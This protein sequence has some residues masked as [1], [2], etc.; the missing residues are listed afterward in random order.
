MTAVT[1]VI[2]SEAFRHADA[3]LRR[4]VSEAGHI[5][6]D[7]SDSWW[8]EGFPHGLGKSATVFHGSLGNADRIA[9]ELGW[10]PGTYCDA[11]KFCCSAWYEGARP[12]LLHTDWRIL[13]A[14]DLVATAPS[15]AAE[16]GGSD[17]VFVRPDSP[18]KPFSGRVVDASSVTLAALDHG[19][20][21]DDA[22]LPIVVAPVRDVGRE[23]RFLVVNKTAV[24]GSGYDPATRSADASSLDSRALDFAQ[25][26]AARLPPPADV[27]ILD[28]CESEGELRLLELN[29][30]G[31]ADLYACDA[32]VVVERVSQAANQAWLR[33][34]ANQGPR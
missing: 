16:I 25:T 15:I 3:G 2:E 1:W 23:W 28:L 27:Y 5:A 9:R 29:P 20:Y 19:F 21:F 13:P 4:A 8:S 7:W 34:Q 30:F 22:S 18:L 6:I 32:G 26:I 12:W 33:Q 14:D 31:G 10:C 11:A 24:T 17:R